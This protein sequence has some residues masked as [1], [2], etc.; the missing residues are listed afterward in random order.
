MYESY[1]S[2]RER[3]FDLTPNPRYLFLTGGHREAL[4][5]LRYGIRGGRGLTLL[6]GD[7]GT[8]KTTLVRTALAECGGPDSKHVYINNPTLT[9]REFMEML[10][11][12]FDLSPKA[13]ESKTHLLLELTELLE[14]QKNSVAALIVDEAQ[15]LP[16]ELL[17]EVRLLAN[18]ETTTKKLM[19]VVLAGQ[20]ELADRLNQPSLRQLKQR[21]ALR[22]VLAPLTYKETVAYIS[23]RLRIAGGDIAECFTEDAIA[24]IHSRS[25]GIPRTVSVICDNSLITGFAGD[26]KPVTRATV[27]DVCR[28][29]DFE[30]SGDEQ[31]RT[32]AR[33]RQERHRPAPETLP[34][35]VPAGVFAAQGNGN[36][37]GHGNGNGNGAKPDSDGGLFNHFSRPRRFLFF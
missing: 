37:N 18:I 2:L 7:A 31:Q 32:E 21:V 24:A 15:S 16:D 12:K 27:L 3:P 34:M 8:G 26:E 10:A 30:P 23:R 5:N 19:P 9:R 11:V 35:P 4:V 6:I 13:I 20:P 17:E 25:R 14:N 1:F 33:E 22:C 29:F 28:D 36:G